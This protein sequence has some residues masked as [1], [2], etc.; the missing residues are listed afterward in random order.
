[1][2]FLIF[3]ILAVLFLSGI[4]CLRVHNNRKA[5]ANLKDIPSFKTYYAKQFLDHFNSRDDRV[6][7]ERYLV[8][9]NN[10]DILTD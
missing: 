9:G 8:N 6:F 1:M 10:F 4:D 7:Q 2:R 3:T 5:N